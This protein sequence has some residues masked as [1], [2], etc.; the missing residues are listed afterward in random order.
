MPLRGQRSMA[1][2]VIE[3]T[4]FNYEVR[5]DLRGCHGLRG[6]QM[7]VRDMHID[8][9]VIE[10]VDFNSGV[11]LNFEAIEAIL[12]PPWPPKWLF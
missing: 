7:A 8:T 6:H 1:S 2:W 5:C 3:V 11:N 4:E 9:R 10:F 12:R